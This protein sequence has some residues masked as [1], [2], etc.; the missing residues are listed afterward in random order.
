MI[1]LD[2][3]RNRAWPRSL[4][5]E[6]NGGQLPVLP[7]QALRYGCAVIILMTGLSGCSPRDGV[8]LSDTAVTVPEETAF[9]LPAPGGPA[10]VNIVERRFHNATQQD[11]FLFTSA[12]TPGQNVLRVQ[13]F[14]PVGSQFEGTQSL[15]YSS[16]RATEI[17]KEMR[18][19]L[20][21]IALRQSPVYL[22]NNY[23]PFSYAYGH[24]R[25]NDACLYGWQQIRSPEDARTVFQNRGT[26]QVRLRMCEE[27]A[28]EEKLLN[29]MYGYTIRSAFNVAGWNPYGEPPTVDPNLGRTGNPIYPKTEDLREAVQPVVGVERP[30][31]VARQK[32]VVHSTERAQPVKQPVAE[33]TIPLPSSADIG[34]TVV[35]SPG[36]VGQPEGVVPCK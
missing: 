7:I 21:G 13:L 33:E 18:R 35:P 32:P 1:R 29:T 22:Q 12:S 6:T 14:G 31:P 11:I 4:S 9:A 19:E 20:P 25:G 34:G 23:G 26:I 2:M 3:I 8:K 16:I 17:A 5:E 30:R 28:S 36:C 27:G 15:G 24:G 10:V